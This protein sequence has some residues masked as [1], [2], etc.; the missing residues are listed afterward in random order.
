MV[1]AARGL[2]AATSLHE[3]LIGRHERRSMDRAT[4]RA[5]DRDECV[6]GCR[7]PDRRSGADQDDRCWRPVEHG[8][9]RADDTEIELTG[10][11]GRIALEHQYEALAVVGDTREVLPGRQS[12]DGQIRVVPSGRCRVDRDDQAVRPGGATAADEIDPDTSWARIPSDLVHARRVP[13]T[14]YRTVPWD[15]QDARSGPF[16]KRAGWDSNPRPRD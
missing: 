10:C 13:V 12:V 7:Q 6:G 2:A 4:W 1:D 11:D 9:A 5:R 3:D 8:R 16:V 15:G 14:G